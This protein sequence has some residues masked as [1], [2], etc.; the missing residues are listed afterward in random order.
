[1][2]DKEIKFVIFFNVFDV[3]RTVVSTPPVVITAKVT[4]PTRI[5]VTVET[6]NTSACL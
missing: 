5:F 6:A 3:R 2:N 4:T 1:M